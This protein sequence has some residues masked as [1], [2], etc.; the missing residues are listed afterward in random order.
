MAHLYRGMLFIRKFTDVAPSLFAPMESEVEVYAAPDLVEAENT[1]PYIAIPKNDS[2]SW[3]VIWYVRKV[4]ADLDVTIGSEQLLRYV[5]NVIRDDGTLKLKSVNAQSTGPTLYAYPDRSW[6]GSATI[7]LTEI[8]GDKPLELRI[9]D[10]SGKVV[11]TQ[12]D[13]HTPIISLHTC[14]PLCRGLYFVNVKSKSTTY[15]RTLIL[16]NR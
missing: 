13:V 11:F 10:L 9:S 3:S 5:K 2:I 1:G 16:G 14:P 7:D 15:T 8:L 12:R 4:P 6:N